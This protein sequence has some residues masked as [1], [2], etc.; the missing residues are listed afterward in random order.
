[1]LSVAKVKDIGLSDSDKTKIETMTNNVQR[2]NAHVIP[3]K[4]FVVFWNNSLIKMDN[5]C[6]SRNG[7]G[8]Y[9]PPLLHAF[10]LKSILI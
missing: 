10:Y 2:K 5:G 9:L 4:L 8:K 7:K 3:T 1:M 6:S